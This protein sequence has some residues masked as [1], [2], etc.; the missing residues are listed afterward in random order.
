M[1]RPISGASMNPARTLGPAI[2]MRVYDEIWV[3]MVGPMLGTLLGGFVYNL[4]RFTDK[5]LTQ[6]TGSSSF[7]KSLSKSTTTAAP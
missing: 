5:P 2:V 6:L 1:D 3:Y 7:V 4:I